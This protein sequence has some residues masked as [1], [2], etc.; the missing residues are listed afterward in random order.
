MTLELRSHFV[1]VVLSVRCDVAGSILKVE[2]HIRSVKKITSSV[3]VT[4]IPLP[5]WARMPSDTLRYET[6]ADK[7]DVS[8]YELERRCFDLEHYPH[9]PPMVSIKTDCK[10]CS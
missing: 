8:P 3:S 9:Y 2:E 5:P 7:N 1:L 10:V 4:P 6:D